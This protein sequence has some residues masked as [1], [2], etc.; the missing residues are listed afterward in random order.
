M[1]QGSQT[2]YLSGFFRVCSGLVRIV[3]EV[4]F[5][6]I[7]EEL[8]VF[9]VRVEGLLQCQGMQPAIAHV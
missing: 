8:E 5:P 6:Y 2:L 9:E 3:P 4:L 1:V 7:S